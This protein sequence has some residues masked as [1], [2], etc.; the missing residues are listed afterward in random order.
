MIELKIRRYQPSDHEI[1]M[2]LHYAGVAQFDPEQAFPS[3]YDDDLLD[4]AGNYI[5]D[6]GDFL[7]GEMGGEIV[8]MGGLRRK[9]DACGEITRLRVRRDLQG[10][11]LGTTVLERLTARAGEL[12]YTELFLDTL[13]GNTPAHRFFEKAGFTRSGGGNIGRYELYY[14]MKKL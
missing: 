6:H 10:K 12:G 1:V 11:G 13:R 7:V 14:Y 8:A 2:T 4:V 3:E 5:G 9:T